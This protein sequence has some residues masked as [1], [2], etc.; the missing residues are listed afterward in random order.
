MSREA[1]VLLVCCCDFRDG[2]ER[3]IPSKSLGN[4]VIR[5]FPG[6]FRILRMCAPRRAAAVVRPRGR[7]KSADRRRRILISRLLII[8]ASVP[9]RKSPFP[10]Y[11][12]GFPAV[13]L[14]IPPYPAFL[15]Y[16]VS[17]QSMCI[18]VFLRY[19]KTIDKTSLAMIEGTILQC[20]NDSVDSIRVAACTCIAHI[21]GYCEQADFFEEKLCEAAID[22]STHVRQHLIELCHGNQISRYL[23][24]R[25]II[26]ILA[27]DSCYSVRQNARSILMSC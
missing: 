11:F 21:L 1:L 20:F 7:E 9:R 25:R 10:A 16:P 17:P 5:A 19:E 24:K 4:A 15:K 18:E 6:L 13:S 8:R 27:D 12:K 2:D 23:L 14:L 26:G 3:L 22:P